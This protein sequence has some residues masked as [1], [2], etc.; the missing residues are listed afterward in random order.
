MRRATTGGVAAVIFGAACLAAFADPAELM[1]KPLEGWTVS[2]PTYGESVIAR[3]GTGDVPPKRI[4]VSRDYM[5]GSSGLRIALNTH[6]RRGVQI[7][8]FVNKAGKRDPEAASAL[9]AKGIVPFSFAAWQGVT[10]RAQEDGE[11]TGAALRLGAH[12][13]LTLEGMNDG[14]P[15]TVALDQVKAYLKRTDLDRMDKFVR[16]SNAVQKGSKT[17]E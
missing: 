14:E 17:A 11:V 1:P 4:E 9:A 2:T 13:T 12:G 5:N 16:Q 3:E 7:I 6:D 15:G 10:M 8:E